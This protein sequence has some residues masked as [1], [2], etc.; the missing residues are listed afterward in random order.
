MLLSLILATAAATAAPAPAG[1]VTTPVGVY[2]ETVSGQ[3]IMPPQ[4]PIEV[5]ASE[6]AA[7]AGSALPVHRH[8]YQR[9]V[10]VMSGRIRMVNLDTG[11]SV[12]F[13]AGDVI[14]EPVGQWHSG[15]VLGDEPV[16]LFAIDQAPPGQSNMER[17]PAP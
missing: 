10:R 13:K 8:P 9:Y 2:K 7:P 5:T 3:P 14:V 1:P 11:K 15:E 12:E 6:T 4:G 16:R 17:R